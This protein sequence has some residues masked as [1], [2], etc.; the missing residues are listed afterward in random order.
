MLS[1]VSYFF[2]KMI[3]HFWGRFSIINPGIQ[4][5]IGFCR[6]P[7]TVLKA[8]CWTDF[9]SEGGFTYATL[10]VSNRQRERAWIET[11]PPS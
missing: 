11:A 4:L 5:S 1:M 7:V 9:F 2:V 8:P 10:R 3:Y 6:N